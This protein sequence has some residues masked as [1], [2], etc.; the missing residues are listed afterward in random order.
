MARF[1]LGSQSP[2]RREVLS[3]FNLSFEQIPSGFDEDALVF[4]GKPM[5]YVTSLSK[6]KAEELFQRHPQATILTADTIVYKD[7]K[8]YGK[9]KHPE[10]ALKTLIELQ[11]AWHS[12]YTA[13]CLKRGHQ[14]FEQVEETRVLFNPLTLKEMSQYIHQMEWADK[15]GGYAIQGAGGLIVRKIDGCYYNVMGMPVNALRSIL[16]HIGIDLWE[17]LKSKTTCSFY[18]S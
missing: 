12:V 16:L 15:A 14:L 18:R 4:E 11:G 2:R 3:F 13:L 1:I 6:E 10:E 7:G 9:P 17:R 8:T 5:E